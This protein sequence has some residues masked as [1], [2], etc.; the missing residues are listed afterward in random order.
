MRNNGEHPRHF[1][2]IF[3][4]LFKVPETTRS[5]STSAMHSCET[6]SSAFL[7]SSNGAGQFSRMHQNILPKHKLSLSL[8]SPPFTT[9]SVFTTRTMKQRMQMNLPNA[10][11]A[12]AI[13]QMHPHAARALF[14]ICSTTNLQRLLRSSSAFRSLQRNAGVLPTVRHHCEGN[15]GRLQSIHAHEGYCYFRSC[16]CTVAIRMTID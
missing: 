1:L 11:V 14:R 13:H 6:L 7:V 9:L 8:L 10:T 16:T 5:Y 4:E 2:N 3:I 12:T 15:V